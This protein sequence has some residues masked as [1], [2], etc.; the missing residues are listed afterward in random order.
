VF[1]GFSSDDKP[2]QLGARNVP[3]Q[4]PCECISRSAVRAK[5]FLHILLVRGKVTVL[6]DERIGME[7]RW[8]FS[9]QSVPFKRHFQPAHV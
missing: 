6:G 1:T 3:Q 5:D 8:Q 9:D 2:V 7:E 4:S